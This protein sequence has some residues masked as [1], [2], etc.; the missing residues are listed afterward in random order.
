MP[1][2]CLRSTRSL[3][4]KQLRDLATMAQGFQD[5]PI[6]IV[7]GRENLEIVADAP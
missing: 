4:N 1:A 5:W 3:Y 2:T 7:G 6:R